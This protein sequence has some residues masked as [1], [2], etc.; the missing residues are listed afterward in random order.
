MGQID[1]WNH[2]T[3]YHTELVASVASD[4]TR[5]LDIGCGDGLLLQKLASTS[6]HITGIDPDA[7]ALT[8]ARER[9]SDHPD[10]Q[11]AGPR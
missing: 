9:L 5:V 11:M 8:S 2:N 10:A 1:Y 7:A 3:A 4:A 6:R